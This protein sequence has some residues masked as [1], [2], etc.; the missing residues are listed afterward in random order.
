MFN[1]KRDL[2]N[3]IKEVSVP[4]TTEFILANDMVNICTDASSICWDKPIPEDFDRRCKYIAARVNTGHESVIEHSNLVTLAKLPVKDS[5]YTLIKFLETTDYLKHKTVISNDNIYILMAGSIRA[6]KHCYK[7]IKDP[8]NTIL[9]SNKEILKYNIPSAFFNDLIKDGIIREEECR[10]FVENPFEKKNKPYSSDY[11]DIVNIDAINHE[12]LKELLNLGFD[13]RDIF[14]M[15]T[16]TV[17]FKNMSRTCTHQLVRH[18]NAI[19]QE[20]QRYVNYREACFASPD[21]FKDKYNGCTYDTKLFDHTPMTMLDIGT[22]LTSVYADMIEA[23]VEK[24]DAR[25]FLPSNIQ[26]KKIYMTFTFTHLIKF[27]E[28]RTDKHAQAEIRMFAKELQNGLGLSDENLLNLE[29]MILEPYYK[30]GIEEINDYSNID[31]LLETTEE[32][33]PD[34]EIKAEAKN[35]VGLENPT[36]IEDIMVNFVTGS[37]NSSSTGISKF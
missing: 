22:A 35:D 26:C 5:T 27:L 23:G 28:L 11:L 20:S 10:S 9:A 30:V 33:D 4:V 18:R 7:T 15:L 3:P 29:H 34:S 36:D 13:V 17:L 16:V 14:N 1:R 37:H 31:E 6:Y 32:V 24:E 8:A 19:T 12:W 25:A 21:M 2:I